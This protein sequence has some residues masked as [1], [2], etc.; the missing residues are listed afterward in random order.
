MI[1]NRPQVV[2]PMSGVGQRFV[3]AGFYQVKPLIPIGNSKIIDEV[4]AMF[5]GIVDPLFIVSKDHKQNPELV[6]Y[7][8]TKWPNSIISEIP[9]HKLGPGHAIYE[10]REYID[11]VRPVIISYCDFSGNW[12]FEEFCSELSEVDSLILTYT[13]FHPH[14]LRNTK[15][16]YVKKN[17]DGLVTWIQEKNSFTDAPTLE[18]ASAGLYAFANGALLL[19]AL[20]EQLE[21]NYS[22]KGEFYIS[23]TIIPLLK[24]NYKV[25]TFLME[26]FFQFGTPED[27]NDWRYLYSSVNNKVLEKQIDSIKVV[28]PETAVILAGG[29][30]SR[31]SD[32][33]Q[34]P[35][36]FLKVKGKELWKFSGAAIDSA[37]NKYL[38]LRGEF[39]KY[40]EEKDL[41]DIQLI[42][43]KNP[44]QGQC[45]TARYFL[46][47]IKEVQGPVTFLS[48]DNYIN[49]TDYE[50]SIKQLQNS[51]LVVWAC[52]NYPMSKYNPARYSWIN[53]EK[54]NVVGFSLKEL[55][56]N[57]NHP[58]MVIG[59]FTFKNI[60]LARKL[61][62]ECFKTGERY[63]SEIYLDSVV[64]NALE[65]GLNVSTFNLDNFFAVGTEDEL[66]TY[67]YYLNSQ[68]SDNFKI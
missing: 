24:L 25:K 11:L 17:E 50:N 62:N 37:S 9:S 66:N 40:L 7:L 26:K 59:N 21:K 53:I 64:Q 31:L 35:K 63:N 56:S 46:D 19:K 38:I 39:T 2:I 51:D 47:N 49:K 30:G 45:D 22:H 16:A 43:L 48:C 4:M 29:V 23:L 54:S 58:S 52:E 57:F 60:V 36:P 20:A 33:S 68:M 55:P 14:M 13:G 28:R 15:Y 8:K 27:L 3:D 41:T 61:I 18:E 5:P 67:R 32:F 34:V 12:N 42:T 44:T 65:L 10:S 1:N 6:S